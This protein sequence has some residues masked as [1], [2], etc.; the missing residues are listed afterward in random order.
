MPLCLLSF[1]NRPRVL[2]YWFW[3]R[4][5]NGTAKVVGQ[6]Q[7]LICKLLSTGL[8]CSF[9]L[10]CCTQWRSNILFDLILSISLN[11][12]HVHRSAS[13]SMIKSAENMITVFHKSMMTWMTLKKECIKLKKFWRVYKTDLKIRWTKR[14]LSKNLTS[15]DSCC[16]I[17]TKKISSN[18]FGINCTRASISALLA[19]F[20]WTEQ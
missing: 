11:L 20:F 8:C 3:F 18:H 2:W 10:L 14:N 9:F 16:S 15:W 17:L 6:S 13:R 12:T 7:R 19:N 4:K 1:T 5:I